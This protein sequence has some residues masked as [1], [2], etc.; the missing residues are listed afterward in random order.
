MIKTSL[1]TAILYGFENSGFQT[2]R[3]DIY[4]EENLYEN[5]NLYRLELSDRE[6]VRR[7]VANYNADLIITVSP[8]ITERFKALFDPS[9]TLINNLH[10][11][12]HQEPPI[13]ILANDIVC[14]STFRSCRINTNVFYNQKL[15][16]FSAFTGAFKTEERL[17]RA[18]ESL[19]NQTYPNWEWIIVDDSPIDHNK[20]WDIA[21]DIASQDNRVK[22]IV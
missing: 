16:Y 8:E 9:D 5:V 2:I 6:G 21:N 13:N 20:T 10:F 7:D 17:Y 15:P 22:Y 18:Y 19:K 14:Q 11:S 1:P 4:F 12:Y 3:S